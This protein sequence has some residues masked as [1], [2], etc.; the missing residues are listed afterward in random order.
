LSWWWLSVLIRRGKTQGEP[1]R[2]FAPAH[3]YFSYATVR[4]TCAS[5][6]PHDKCHGPEATFVMP[7]QEECHVSGVTFGTTAGPGGGGRLPA[8][9]A[10]SAGAWNQENSG[11]QGG[12][13]TGSGVRTPRGLGVRQSAAALEGD[14]R[15]EGPRWR[16][17]ASA[18]AC[19][20]GQSESARGLAHS[21][22][23]RDF[24][25]HLGNPRCLGLRREAHSRSRSG[26]S[27]RVPRFSTRLSE[28]GGVRTQGR[29][30]GGRKRCGKLEQQS[31]R[32][33]S[34]SAPLCHRTPRRHATSPRSLLKVDCLT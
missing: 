24:V 17:A 29:A 31:R 34:Q 1:R 19:L 7:W 16:T 25:R 14:H 26:P 6:V 27:K 20:R 3:P 23:L 33:A 15:R 22:M 28:G 30:S 5:D 2:T 10:F 32:I 13:P 21:K 12:N 4:R 8:G 18:G 11:L 9:G